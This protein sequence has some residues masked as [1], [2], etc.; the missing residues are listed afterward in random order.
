MTHVL[1]AVPAPFRPP[2]CRCYYP[3][4]GRARGGSHGG[5]CRRQN[6]WE[7]KTAAWCGA[8]RE[9]SRGMHCQICLARA[10]IGAYHACCG[11]PRAAVSAPR[12]A[13]TTLQV[14]RPGRGETPARAQRK[15]WMVARRLAGCRSASVYAARAGGTR[16]RVDMADGWYIHWYH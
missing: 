12:P 3:C 5:L 14:L 13:R 1:Y 10:P 9:V 15:L 16:D 7:G 6:P 8:F 2:P 11:P 4:S